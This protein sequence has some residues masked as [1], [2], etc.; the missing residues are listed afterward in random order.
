MRK[1]ET[2]VVGVDASEGGRAAFR[3]AVDEA[4][5][6]GARLRAIFAWT[7]SY[8]RG[9]GYGYMIGPIESVPYGGVSDQRRAAEQ[10]LER[11][12]AHTLADTT[13]LD[14]ERE[15]IEGSAADVLVSAASEADLLVV[16]SRG[17]GGFVGLLL[18]SVSQQCA[19]HA[20]CP[21]VIVRPAE[22]SDDVDAERTATGAAA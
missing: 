10:V 11:A 7:L 2:I 22:P 14:I 12:T 8:P 3:W 20:S 18:G 9:E 15:V 6:R 5:V 13:G 16:G 19:H 1:R 4:R 21:V 17:H